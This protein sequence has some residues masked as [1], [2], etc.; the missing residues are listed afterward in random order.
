MKSKTQ[1]F[2]DTFARINIRKSILTEL[3]EITPDEFS[4]TTAYVNHL[5]STVVAQSGTGASNENKTITIQKQ[6]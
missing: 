6:I 4:S 2:N 1:K 3:S 5:L